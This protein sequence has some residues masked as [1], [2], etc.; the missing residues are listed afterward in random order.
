M[1]RQ[2]AASILSTRGSLNT[3]L[4]VLVG[5]DSSEADSPGQW[6]SPPR[7]LV[8]V[9]LTNGESLISDSMELKA[10]LIAV[11]EVA[12]VDGIGG[13]VAEYRLPSPELGFIAVEEW[14]V[15]VEWI[16]GISSDCWRVSDLF[17]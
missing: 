6:N 7:L 2:G 13:E 10:E 14:R 8:S 15:E 3:G 17:V 5:F 9:L 12:V 1:A 11:T 16:S 4:M